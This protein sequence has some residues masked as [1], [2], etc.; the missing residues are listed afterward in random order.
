MSALLWGCITVIVFWHA[1]LTIV[2]AFV[3]GR[4]AWLVLVGR[5]RRPRRGRGAVWR[6]L[7]ELAE[8]GLLAKIALNTRAPKGIVVRREIVP[9]YEGRGPKGPKR[10]AP[11]PGDLP[12][13]Y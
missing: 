8:T 12:E 10:P 7:L 4:F 13:G 1:I 9:A 3:V 2:A 5:S 11:V 6:G